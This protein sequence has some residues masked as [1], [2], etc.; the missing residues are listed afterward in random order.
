MDDLFNL[1]AE[2]AIAV[3]GFTAIV[4]VFGPH[5]GGSGGIVQAIR[6]KMMLEVSIV[7]MFASLLPLLIGTLGLPAWVTWRIAGSVMSVFCVLLWVSQLRLV[8]KR[9]IE[10]APGY[11]RRAAVLT[12][13]M[14]AFGTLCFLGS[15]VFA[16]WGP[17][18][19]IYAVGVLNSLCFAAVQF[20]RA[21]IAAMDFG[22]AEGHGA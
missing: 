14:G 4:S 18:A 22:R 9:D 11:S 5:R 10:N 1:F 21:A 17:V 15:T 12:K 7:T 3:A 6:V 2:L 16:K 20:M 8:R 13:G 19:T